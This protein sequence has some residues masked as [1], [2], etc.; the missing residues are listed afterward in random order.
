MAA[1]IGGAARVFNDARDSLIAGLTS[2]MRPS[3]TNRRWV[4]T[5]APCRQSASAWRQFDRRWHCRADRDVKFHGGFGQVQ[6]L[7]EFLDGMLL[8]QVQ[9]DG[10]RGG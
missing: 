3:V 6:I 7:D 4:F 1:S 10:G 5:C 2:T 9:V 8:L